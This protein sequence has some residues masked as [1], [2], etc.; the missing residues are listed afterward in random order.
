MDEGTLKLEQQV[1]QKG[2]GTWGHDKKPDQSSRQNCVR[3]GKKKKKKSLDKNN[4][5]MSIMKKYF[6]VWDM[7]TREP[8]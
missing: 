6:K 1:E 4:E 5:Q 3:P 8:K 2:Q 7:A